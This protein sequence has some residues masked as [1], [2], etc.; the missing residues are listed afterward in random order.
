MGK[1][2]RRDSRRLPE[3][4]L[5]GAMTAVLA[6]TVVA[7]FN[8]APSAVFVRQSLNADR[9]RKAR[10]VIRLRYLPGN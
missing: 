9:S 5:V 3:E 8:D 2:L 6:Q 10:A 4:N 7:T 1:G